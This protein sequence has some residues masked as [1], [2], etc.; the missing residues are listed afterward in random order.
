MAGTPLFLITDAGLAVAS[1]AGFEGPYI[2]IAKFKVGSGF[3]Y[4]PQRTDPGLNGNLLFEGIPTTYTNIGN[5]TIDILLEIPPD[6]G[7]FDFGEVGV[8]LDDGTMFAKAV[9]DVPQTKF[10]SLGTNVVSSYSFHCLLKLQQ[11]TAVFQIDTLNG[12]P[13]VWTVFKWSDVFPPGISA[14]PDIPLTMVRELNSHGDSS[15]LTNTNDSY[16]SLESTSYMEYASAT[17]AAFTVANSTTSWIEIPAGLCRPSDLTAVNSRFLIE[18]ADK[19]FRSVSSVVVSGGNYRFFLNPDPLLNAPGVGSQI[20]IY[21]DDQRGGT[22]YYN[23]IV[24]PPAIPPQ[25]VL[26]PATTSTRGGVVVGD[27]IFVDG[28]GRISVAPPTA[29][30]TLPIANGGQLGGVKIGSGIIEAGDGTIS[31]PP[32]TPY[33]PSGGGVSSFAVGGG[34][35]TYTAT[36]NGVFMAW[37]VDDQSR[38]TTLT[39]NGGTTASRN[40]K[41]GSAGYG[42]IH[43]D[44]CAFHAGDV[45][46]YTTT[47]GSATITIVEYAQ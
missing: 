39:I 41:A 38:N 21:R 8:F 40:T 10:S 15:L 4:E 3:G 44:I 31:V 35:Y 43:H 32:P 13:A 23:Q 9:F 34:T 33:T 24:D 2:H 20:R 12:P 37:I 11:S 26:P 16:W 42:R 46:R 7:P 19:F 6:A 14:N 29:P 5:N 47:G 18:T 36:R 28:N 30:Y 1:T 27:N 25:Y 22:L 45:I 17:G